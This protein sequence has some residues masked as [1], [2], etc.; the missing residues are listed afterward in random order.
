MPYCTNIFK[1]LHAF[2]L[3][4]ALQDAALDGR[5]LVLIDPPYEPYNEYLTLNLAAVQRRTVE[6]KSKTAI[7]FVGVPFR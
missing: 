5:V 1:R 4:L 3:K 6:E 7:D 2:N